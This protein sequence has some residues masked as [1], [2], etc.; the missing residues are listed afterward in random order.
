ME[1]T[2]YEF[3]FHI[4]VQDLLK[5]VAVVFPILMW[6]YSGTIENKKGMKLTVRILSL[7][8]AVLFTWSLFIYPIV[9][10]R[11]THKAILTD[12][13]YV[14][15]GEV[16]DFDTPTNSFGGHKTESFRISEIDFSYSGTENYGYHKL[17]CDG[18]VIEGNGQKLRVTYYVQTQTG[19]NIICKIES[20]P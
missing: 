3:G 6:F 9:E 14:V 20:V 17:R 5:I 12:H 13:V 1:C 2:L 11:K 8:F 10:Y 7:C 19:T 15:E 18:G 4:H 16:T